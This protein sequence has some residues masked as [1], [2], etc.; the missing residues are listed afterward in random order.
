[1]GFSIYEQ[2]KVCGKHKM[3][4]LERFALERKLHPP[5]QKKAYFEAVTF[6]LKL[7][8]LHACLGCAVY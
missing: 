8:H 1:M 7:L 3:M 2:N 6:I 4:K 5:T